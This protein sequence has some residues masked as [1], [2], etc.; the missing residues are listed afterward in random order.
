M[1]THKHLKQ[2]L[3]IHRLGTLN[4]AATALNISQPALT[5]SLNKLE[6]HLG[7]SLFHRTKKGVEA[8]LFGQHII[9]TAPDILSR[10][11]RLEDELALLAGGERGEIKI[12]AGP[13]FMHGAMRAII[14][15][16]CKRYPDLRLTLL[17]CTP[18][19][20][21]QDV[22]TGRLDLGF[23][24]ISQAPTRSDIE[25]RPLIEEPVAFV[26]A[27]DHPL[28]ARATVGKDELFS[29]PFATPDLPL[30]LQV[31]ADEFSSAK[32]SAVKNCL[33]TSDYELLFST[34]MQSH[35]ISGC[36]LH[37]AKPY[38]KTGE[39]CA[40]NYTGPPVMWQA[41][42]VYRKVSRYSPS[43]QILLERIEQ[44]FRQAG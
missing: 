19:R 5:A 12:G 3:T 6:E 36:P 40:L 17:T 28:S 29:F 34:V 42:A 7:M 1:L 44:W 30:E 27:K 21:L 13:V 18:R 32:G 15:A 16:F 8:T 26:A 4:R 33:Q 39:L 43:F 14:P 9:E 10:V 31:Q 2:V 25:I 22:E 24:T 41:K 11:T 35:A 20:I 23:G 38:L 37:L